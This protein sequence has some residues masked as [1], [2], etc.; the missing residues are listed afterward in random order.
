MEEIYQRIK[1]IHGCPI[2][3]LDNHLR[4]IRLALALNDN[5]GLNML[6][7]RFTFADDGVRLASLE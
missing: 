1:N 5:H 3:G 2:G 6:I 7:N 4:E